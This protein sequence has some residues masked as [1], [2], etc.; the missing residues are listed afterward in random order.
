LAKEI[1]LPACRKILKTINGG[2]ADIEISKIS[3]Q[4]I[5]RITGYNFYLKIS[6]LVLQKSSKFLFWNTN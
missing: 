5:R 6:S 4:M 1:I 2:A 3:F